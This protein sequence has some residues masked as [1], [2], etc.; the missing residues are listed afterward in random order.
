MVLAACAPENS[1]G[2][3]LSE[4]IP[5]E[6]S[7]VDVYRNDEALQVTYYRNRGVFVDVVIRISVSLAGINFKPGVTIPLGGETSPNHPRTTVATAPGGEPVRLMPT[8]KHGDMH[9]RSG[10]EPGQV[11]RGDFSL[12]FG[13][14]GG[15][16]GFDRNLNG[17]F[18]GQTVD[19]GFG[20]P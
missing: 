12:Q 20:L 18:A 4:V 5:L 14:T 3:S 8:V 2:G 19:A 13:S 7:R 17:N 11:T 15:D 9:I 16:L 6:T 10:G 1:L